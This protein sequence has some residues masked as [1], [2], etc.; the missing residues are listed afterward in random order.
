MQSH[1]WCMAKCDI[2]VILATVQSGICVTDMETHTHLCVN[3]C[4]YTDTPQTH[5]DTHRHRQTATNAHTVAATGTLQ[6]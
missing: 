5:T 2:I 4:T 6:S 3:T 1:A